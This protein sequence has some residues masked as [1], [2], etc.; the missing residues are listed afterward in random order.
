VP[1]TLAPL[2]LLSAFERGCGCNGKPDVPLLLL[3]A[4]AAT[5]GEET[6]GVSVTGSDDVVT[7]VSVCR[8]GLLVA[9]P[10]PLP[11][12]L[13]L[14]DAPATAQTGL[15]SATRERI[16]TAPRPKSR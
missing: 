6:V 12:A 11:P 8:C 13:D 2:P 16:A 4:G 5:A 7:T 9:T 1:V 3:T 15:A 10:L 14:A